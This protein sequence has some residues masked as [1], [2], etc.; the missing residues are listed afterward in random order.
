MNPPP[1]DA[2]PMSIIERLCRRLPPE[3]ATSESEPVERASHVSGGRFGLAPAAHAGGSQTQITPI[4]ADKKKNTLRQSAQSAFYSSSPSADQFF[5]E[6][7]GVDVYDPTTGAI[8]NSSTGPRR[9][10]SR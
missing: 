4:D 3:G 7:K 5:V 6:V 10:G 9:S 2:A 1:T 8:R